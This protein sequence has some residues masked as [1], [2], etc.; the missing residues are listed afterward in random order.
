[1][2]RRS[3][4]RNGASFFD[5]LYWGALAFLAK[6]PKRLFSLATSFRKLCGCGFCGTPYGVLFLI[7]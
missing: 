1:M 7:V 2:K 6:H 5:N 3:F 4:C